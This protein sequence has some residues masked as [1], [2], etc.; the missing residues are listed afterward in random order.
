M[1][2]TTNTRLP[3]PRAVLLTVFSRPSHDVRCQDQGSLRNASDWQVAVSPFRLRGDTHE[4]RENHEIGAVSQRGQ[5]QGCDSNPTMPSGVA[6]PA[7]VL[8]SEEEGLNDAEIEAT[9]PD[10]QSRRNQNRIPTRRVRQSPL[11]KR[12]HLTRP[13]KTPSDREAVPF[14]SSSFA[15]APRAPH[16]KP[17]QKPRAT[18]MQGASCIAATAARSPA[19]PTHKCSH[20]PGAGL[21]KM[22]LA[23]AAQ[24]KRREDSPLPQHE[25]STPE[26]RGPFQP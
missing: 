19:A 14:Q 22:A 6:S 4:V 15:L 16:R 11:A 5:R 2:S 18:Q 1:H 9:T 8:G 7:G 25:G 10:G 13:E 12:R 24:N 3:I 20:P 23:H 21:P 17:T 26:S